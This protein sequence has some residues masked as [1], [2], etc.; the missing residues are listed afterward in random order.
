VGAPP[1]PGPC[2]Q[3]RP[4]GAQ[5]HHPRRRQAHRLARYTI[6]AGERILYGQR[7]DGIV[8]V[9]DRPAG[10]GGR[11]YLVERE[12]ET[13]DEL[14]AL[15]LDYLDQATKLDSPPLAAPAPIGN[16]DADDEEPQR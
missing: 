3:L 5:A 11:A 14:D 2:S 15:I 13:K 9:T 6:S 12:L 7:I 4:T 10:N 8:R 1:P 16:T